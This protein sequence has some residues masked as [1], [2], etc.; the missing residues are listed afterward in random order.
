MQFLFLFQ[1]YVKINL[2]KIAYK[3]YKS[4]IMSATKTVISPGI[5]Y[6]IQPTE[7]IGTNRFKI[8]CSYQSDLRR[9]INGY[10]KGSRYLF[11]ME[12]L[13]PSQL[14]SLIKKEFTMKFKLISGN[15]YFEG[16]E[17]D[18]KQEF[19]RISI[20]FD[21]NN[22]IINQQPEQIKTEPNS[23]ESIIP[24]PQQEPLQQLDPSKLQEQIT[25]QVEQQI[26]RQTQQQMQI[27][28]QYEINSQIQKEIKKHV[29]Q[30]VQK[31]MNNKVDKPLQNQLSAEEETFIRFIK[32]YCSENSEI[33]F[34]NNINKTTKTIFYEEYVKFAEK[35]NYLF[36][37]S[38]KFLSQLKKWEKYRFILYKQQY[39]DRTRYL[40]INR[41]GV[42]EYLKSNK[43]LQHDTNEYNI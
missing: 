23:S 8:G 24:L 20:D 18:I 4:G 11:I 27:Q 2:K 3:L 6:L 13:N 35:H 21:G 16:N 19:I 33:C 30:Q 10:N 9:C 15:E 38:L 12:C 17:K 31:L 5:V 1:F 28:I 26:Q 22:N 7:L 40:E 39:T 41:N 32:N 37:S 42:L 34:T 25:Q 43:Y 14:E 36:M 29:Q